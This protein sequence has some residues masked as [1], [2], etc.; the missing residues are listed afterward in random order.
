MQMVKSVEIYGDK[1][2]KYKEN[3][4]SPHTGWSENQL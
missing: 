3:K 2:E 4:C 1:Y